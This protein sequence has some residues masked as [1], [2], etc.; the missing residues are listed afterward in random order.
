MA[1]TTPISTARESIHGAPARLD[2]RQIEQ[3]IEEDRERHKRAREGIWAVPQE[4]ASVLA[5]DAEFEKLWEEGSELD[6]DDFILTR[7]ESEERAQCLEFEEA[8]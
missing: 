6:E 1:R 8:P 4:N 2:K 3:R 5:E 7:E